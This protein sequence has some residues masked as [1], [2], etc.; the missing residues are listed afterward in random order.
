MSTI[1]TL[2]DMLVEQYGINKT[3][4]IQYIHANYNEK[5]SFKLF[6]SGLLFDLSH[7]TNNIQTKLS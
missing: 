6:L 1:E 3:K 7:N 4:T 5:K 2:I